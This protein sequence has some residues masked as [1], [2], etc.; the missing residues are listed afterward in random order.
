[1]KKHLTTDDCKDWLEVL[2]FMLMGQLSYHTGIV[3]DVQVDTNDIFFVF[4]CRWGVS[5]LDSCATQDYDIGQIKDL[6]RTQMKDVV[7]GIAQR[8]W[9]R[10][11]EKAL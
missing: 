10:Q 7:T 11:R 6:L 4:S 2:R 3:W 9:K 1:M 8:Y 5:Q